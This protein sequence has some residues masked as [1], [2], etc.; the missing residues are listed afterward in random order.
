MR[1]IDYSELKVGDKV[2][3]RDG[4]DVE[5]LKTDLKYENPIVGIVTDDK[6]EQTVGL[7]TKKGR[8]YDDSECN[9]DLFLPPQKRTLMLYK[10]SKIDP[11]VTDH[12][13][14]IIP[15][16]RAPTEYEKEHYKF[17]SEIEIED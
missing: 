1:E 15:L 16:E 4:R 14:I 7:W 13:F 12:E 3:T 2:V 10:L 8:F 17:H 11:V 6:G 9:G 5:I